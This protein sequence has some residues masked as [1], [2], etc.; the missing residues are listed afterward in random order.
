MN[1][2]RNKEYIEAFGNNLRSIRK[3]KKISMEKLALA[4]GIE[5]SQIFDIEHGKINTTISTIH[6]IANALNIAEKDL[7]D[8]TL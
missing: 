8:F 2:N 4:A 6:I 1:N 3:S 5:Y 7:F